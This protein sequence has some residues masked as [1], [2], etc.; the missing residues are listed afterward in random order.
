MQVGIEYVIEYLPARRQGRRRQ[1]GEGR[2]P[3]GATPRFSSMGSWR[4]S[5]TA[6]AAAY[7]TSPDAAHDDR[8]ASTSLLSSSLAGAAIRPGWSPSERRTGGRG[9]RRRSWWRTSEVRGRIVMAAW[10]GGRTPVKQCRHDCRRAVVNCH[11]KI[12]PLNQR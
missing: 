9:R 11:A 4:R 7:A 8:K 10:G 6:S 12:S 5:S 2:S 3:G 1:S